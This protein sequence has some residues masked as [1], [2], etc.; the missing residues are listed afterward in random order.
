MTGR[1][2]LLQDGVPTQ[3]DEDLPEIPYAYDVPSAYDQECGS[4]GMTDFQLPNPQCPEKFIC[5]A[6]SLST[7]GHCIET[8]NCFMF[9]GMTTGVSAGSEIALFLHQMIPHHENAINMAKTLLKEA[10]LSCDTFTDSPD[11]TM[12]AMGL[13]IINDQNF[14]VQ[15]MRGLLESYGFNATN[16]CIVPVSNR[17][18]G[19]YTHYENRALVSNEAAEVVD[20]SR[21]SV[22]DGSAASYIRG[23]DNEKRTLTE[24]GDSNVCISS[25][26]TYT[27][28]VNLFAGELGK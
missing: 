23:G 21:V 2:K 4:Y 12:Y 18:D 15:L 19:G 5:G 14:Q 1:I 28:R 6:G 22:R 25:T 9:I 7:F 10:D 13:E 8:Q 16:D 3:P 11:C 27:V 20:S 17:T 24:G 26:G